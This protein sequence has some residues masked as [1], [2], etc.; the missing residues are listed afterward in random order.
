MED[1][2]SASVA[3]ALAD[4]HPAHDPS[5][6]DILS[7]LPRVELRRRKPGMVDFDVQCGVLTISGTPCTRPIT[8]KLHSMYSKSTVVG[9]SRDFESLLRNYQRR[10]E[11]RFL[12]RLVESGMYRRLCAYSFIYFIR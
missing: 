4:Q 9:R 6:L 10:V 5:S 8:C 12:G 1:A 7:H 2:P 3:V 11:Q